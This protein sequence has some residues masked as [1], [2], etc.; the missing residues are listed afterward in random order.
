MCDR[1]EKKNFFEKDSEYVM[2]C[3]YA[4]WNYES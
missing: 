1:Y 2:Y 4:D 3:N